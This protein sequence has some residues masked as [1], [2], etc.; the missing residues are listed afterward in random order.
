MNFV[1]IDFETA[2]PNRSS[3]CS[4][5]L[6]IV[7]NGVITKSKH[8]YVRPNP[9][10][11]HGINVSIHGISDEHTRDKPTFRTQWKDLKPYFENQTIVAHNAAFDLSVLRKALDESNLR[12]P[13]LEYHCSYRL[14]K[15]TLNL[16]SHKLDVL[17]QHFRI[18]L[19][20][21]NAESDARASAEVAI[22]LMKKFKVGSMDELAAITGFRVGTLSGGPNSHSSFSKR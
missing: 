10:W 4:I 12:Y 16:A 1:A 19:K 5:G 20:H 6:A 3:I 2:N 21:H 22:R 7:R 14:S 17:A 13:D 11:Y 15:E 9:D 8:M 18:S